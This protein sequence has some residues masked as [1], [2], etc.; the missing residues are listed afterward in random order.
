MSTCPFCSE[1]LGADAVQAA[2]TPVSA[3]PHCFNPFMC[4][5][6]DGVTSITPVPGLPDVRSLATEGSIAGAVFGELESALESLP[7]LP[8]VSQRV[9]KVVRDPDSAAGDLA[10]AVGQDQAMAVKV[11]QVANSAFYGGL[12][13]IKDLQTACARLGMKTV[14]NVVQ[15]VASQQ[16]FSSPSVLYK[17]MLKQLWH[18]SLAT[19][20]CAHE[21]ARLLAE[22]HADQLFAA[23]LLHDIGITMLIQIVAN[24]K[25]PILLKLQSEPRLLYEVCDRFHELTGLHAV[26]RWKLPPEFAVAA[27]CHHSPEHLKDAEMERVAHMV[28]MAN[29]VTGQTDFAF[30]REKELPSLMTLPSARYLNLSDV[31]I[32]TLRVDLE[33]RLQA[34]IDV[35]GG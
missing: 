10:E 28:C 6:K 24:S 19:A 3:C 14:A 34:L 1:Q 25:D 11:L 23:G 31:K 27:F 17:V 21:L 4:A 32:A 15:A 12:Q 20:H 9:M 33:D 5:E 7:V 8:E 26:L 16:L 29:A 2:L 18:H 13:E 22:P 30:G 35:I